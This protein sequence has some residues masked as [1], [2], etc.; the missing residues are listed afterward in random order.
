MTAGCGEREKV[1][2][3]EESGEPNTVPVEIQQYREARDVFRAWVQ[4]FQRPRNAT[5]AF[6]LITATGKKRLASIGVTDPA[7]FAGWIDRKEAEQ[8]APFIYEFSRFDIMDIDVRDSMRA[9][10]TATF[11]VHVQQ[12]TFESV[13]SFILKRERGSWRVPFAESGDFE[14]SWWQKEK[15]FL[16]RMVQ[17]GMTDFTSDSLGIT[18]S[19]PR[20]WDV[21]SGVILSFPHHPVQ[22]GIELRYVDPSTLSTAALIRVAPLPVIG[23]DTTATADTLGSARV[24]I[25]DSEQIQFVDPQPMRGTQS[26]LFDPA[27]GR[28]LLYLSVV[29]EQREDYQHFA[30]TFR[31]VQ[32]SILFTSEQ[33]P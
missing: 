15:N 5:V 24:R 10:I 33:I 19:Y 6:P 25:L 17:E 13:S 3:K 4:L 7:T 21:N 23:S 28:R 31:A 11:L 14:S 12:R 9:I 20:T 8:L 2:P 22:R 26:I 27:T 29:D 30:E 32:Q 16:T 1:I 18:L